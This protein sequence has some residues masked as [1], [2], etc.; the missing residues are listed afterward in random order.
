MLGLLIYGARPP[1]PHAI[2]SVMLN[3]IEEQVAKPCHGS[4]GYSPTMQVGLGRVASEITL[5]QV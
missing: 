1:L 5:G 3:K 2:Y 4:S